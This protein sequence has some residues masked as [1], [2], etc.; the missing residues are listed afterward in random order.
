MRAM[1]ALELGRSE[2]WTFAQCIIR[3]GPDTGRSLATSARSRLGDPLARCPLLPRQRRKSRPAGRSESCHEE[4]SGPP[5]ARH[6]GATQLVARFDVIGH[7]LHG[8]ALLFGI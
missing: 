4:T 8:P 6:V 7:G 2:G 5:V 1:S 3:N